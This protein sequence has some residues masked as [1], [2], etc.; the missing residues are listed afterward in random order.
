MGIQSGITAKEFPKQSS[1]KGN[2]VKVCFN[3]TIKDSIEGVIVRDDMEA[4]F[5]TIVKLDDGRY[6][7]GTECQY[8]LLDVK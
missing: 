1:W 7:L 2:K 3:F 5:K 8:S 6:V 4:P